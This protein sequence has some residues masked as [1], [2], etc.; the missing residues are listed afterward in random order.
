MPKD[1]EDCVSKVKAQLI[2]DKGMSE[3][4]A[5]SSAYAICTAQFKK[6]GKSF[7]ESKEKLD[8]DGHIIVDENV[9]LIIGAKITEV[10][11]VKN[12]KKD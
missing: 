10:T 9:K 4:E 6:A 11:E 8:E 1:F 7:K 5:S 3:D 12:D 2:K